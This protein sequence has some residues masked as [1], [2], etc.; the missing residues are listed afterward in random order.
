M[1]MKRMIYTTK[2]ISVLV[3]IA[4]HAGRLQQRRVERR[5]G[6]AQATDA[7]GYRHHGRRVSHGGE[8]NLISAA[9]PGEPFRR[10]SYGR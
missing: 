4:P 2:F 7:H 3:F 1:L 10:G 5:R 8:R 9:F 6:C